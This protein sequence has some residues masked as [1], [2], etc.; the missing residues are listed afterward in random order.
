MRA[1][2]S[3]TIAPGETLLNLNRYLLDMNDAGMFVTVLY[4][5]LQRRTRAFS[6]A[7]AGHEQPIVAERHGSVSMPELGLGHPLGI[8]PDPALDEQTVEIPAGGLLL[9]YTDG[10]TDAVDP[11]GTFFRL[12]RLQAEVGTHHDDPAQATC[13]RLEAT[14]EAYRDSAPQADDITLVAVRAAGS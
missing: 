12:D 3:R 4:G 2:A 14:L 8:V 7:R 1:E 13:D 10:V 5:V 11:D 6:Y 9:L